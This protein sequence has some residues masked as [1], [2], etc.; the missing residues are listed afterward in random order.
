[1]KRTNGIN[2]VLQWATL[3]LGVALCPWASAD[4]VNVNVYSDAADHFWQVY[5][6]DGK[7]ITDANGGPIPP[8]NV[9]LND[10]SPP[11]CP[12]G[13]M[14]FWHVSPGDWPDSLTGR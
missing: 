12:S 11:N 4:V 5:D 9:C 6:A 13:A 1:M 8:Q 7:L 14:K 10:K 2:T 3:F